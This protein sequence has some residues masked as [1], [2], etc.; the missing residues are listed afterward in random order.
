MIFPKC[1]ICTKKKFVQS[2]PQAEE[3]NICKNE[4]VLSILC[5]LVSVDQTVKQQYKDII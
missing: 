3:I 2:I 5:P 1:I 4:H